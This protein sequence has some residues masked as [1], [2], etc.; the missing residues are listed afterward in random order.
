MAT[1][2][3]GLLHALPPSVPPGPAAGHWQPTPPPE[4]P[5]H[6]Q[7]LKPLQE[8][9]ANSELWYAALKS[10]DPRPVRT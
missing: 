7:I 3:K 10:V 6:S 5:G 4:T 9:E 2:F 1:S 8:G